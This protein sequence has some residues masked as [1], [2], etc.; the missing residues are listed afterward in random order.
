MTK[1]D[2]INAVTKFINIYLAV[3][4]DEMATKIK[5]KAIAEVHFGYS[6]RSKIEKSQ[7]SEGYSVVQMRDLVDESF[8]IEEQNIVKAKVTNAK[9]DHFLHQD[10]IVFRSRGRTGFAAFLADKKLEGALLSSPL[11][12]ITVDKSKCVPAYLAWYLNSRESQNYFERNMKGTSVKHVDMAT[13]E[14]LEIPLPSIGKQQHVAVLVDLMR[15]EKLL[16]EYLTGR[17]QY[18]YDQLLT[19]QAYV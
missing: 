17:K 13:L 9:A 6:F 18:Y 4:G 15:R 1:C 3:C 11:V 19:K 8:E 12:K 7:G 16:E 2:R 14:N 5:L 10:D